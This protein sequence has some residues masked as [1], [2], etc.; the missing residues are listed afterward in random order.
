MTKLLKADLCALWSM[1]SYYSP[2]DMDMISSHSS[3]K[4]G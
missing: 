4:T 2:S 3:S 1:K